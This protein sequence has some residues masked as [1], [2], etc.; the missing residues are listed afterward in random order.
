MGQEQSQ[1]TPPSSQPS[2]NI[3]PSA[4]KIKSDY[5]ILIVVRGTRR[6]GRAIY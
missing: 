4:P 1:I 6:T 3:A 2:T 5:E